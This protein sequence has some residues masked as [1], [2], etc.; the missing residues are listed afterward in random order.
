MTP[1][2]RKR[3]MAEFKRVDSAKEDMEYKI[4]DLLSQIERLKQNIVIQQT[5]L[6]ELTIQLKEKE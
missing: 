4:E 2:E 5:K 1:L 3:L 6:D